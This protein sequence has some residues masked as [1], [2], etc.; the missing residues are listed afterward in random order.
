MVNPKFK[1]VGK[2]QPPAADTEKAVPAEPPL[3][4][5]RKVAVSKV[6]PAK[7]KEPTK[8]EAP[9]QYFLVLASLG[10]QPHC[11]VCSSLNEVSEKLQQ[12]ADAVLPEDF[13]PFLFVGKQLP[14]VNDY[15]VARVVDTATNEVV[16]VR[17]TPEDAKDSLLTGQIFKYTDEFGE[18][19]TT[20]AEFSDDRDDLFSL[21]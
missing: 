18:D 9:L 21:D 14:I 3:R 7:P 2:V 15:G 17:R 4:K 13:R 5:M 6:A 12:A 1:V 19:S 16:G 20:Q 10:S 11:E 8:P